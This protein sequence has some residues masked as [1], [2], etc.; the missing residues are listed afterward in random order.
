M[1]K[2]IILAAGKG[3][4][5]KSD[6][7]KV[8][9]ELGNMPMLEHVIDHVTLDDQTQI[10]LVVGYGA[11]QV[12]EYFG[13][14]VQYAYQAEQLGTGHA[15]MMAMDFVDDE[16]EV[17]ITCG[18]TPL[19]SKSDF[20]G[21]ISKKSE[22]YGAV[23][24]SSVV[25]NPTGYGRIIQ[26][27]GLFQEIVE[28]R[29]ATCEQRQITEVNVGT[30]IID[31]ALLKNA[32]SRITNEND[33][34]EYYLTDVFGL[35]AKE[36][37]V[38]TCPILES[39]MLG[40]N[41]KSQLAQAERMLRLQ[42]NEEFMNNGVHIIHPEATYI[43][44]RVRIAPGA[45]IYPNCHLRGNTSIGKDTIIRENSTLENAVV[46]ENCTIW[47]STIV[48]AEVGNNVHVGPYAYLRPKT[49]VFDDCK[50]GDFV[51]LKNAQFG[52]GSKASHLAYIG[53]AV[54]GENVNIG[55][56]VVFVNYDGKNKFVSTIG[57]NA[58]VG[59]NV[60]LVAPV[61]V[62]ENATIAAGSTITEDVPQDTLAIARQR[63]TNKENW[64]K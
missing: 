23:L 12:K 57:N 35:A 28:E 50:I 52:R 16:D 59:S 32:I 44:K 2:V 7:P 9:H 38:T 18:D 15:V 63:Q 37:K 24:M 26:K 4:R 42:I 56:G 41:S 36:S 6:L 49:K 13:E 61:T 45:V 21:M 11:Q 54:V 53:D 29:D 51:E 17:I 3:T 14:R 46:G 48:E 34:R 27:D 19:I 1:R 5:M 39:N 60:N 58:F 55:C 31:G 62:G 43:D 33:Q 22:G 30:Y 8:M 40:I 20:E 25:S 47:S 10:I 64:K